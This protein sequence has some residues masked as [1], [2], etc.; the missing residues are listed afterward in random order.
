[1]SPDTAP[2]AVRSGL[3]RRRGFMLEYV[4]MAWMTAEAVVAIT[5]GVV[6]GSIALIGFGLDS[7]IEFAAAGIVVWQ[8]RGEGRETR[9]VRLIGV[10]FFV[11]A[12]Y[13]AVEGI[14]DLAGHARPEHS[15][16]GLAVAAA[17][18]VVMPLLAVAKRRTGQE[19][20]NR[21]LIADSAETAFCAATS[22]A[23]LLG[24]GLNAGLGWWWADPAAALVIAALAVREGIEAWE[25][26]EDDDDGTGRL[27][28]ETTADPAREEER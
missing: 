28:G 14:R 7:V 21:T 25:D 26:E 18:L 27:P 3:L 6:A 22:A 5:A 23:A 2:A 19:L 12:V 10:T 20:G 1:M 16:A 9:G 17:A 24:T 11:L 4:S 15:V 8:L 13:L